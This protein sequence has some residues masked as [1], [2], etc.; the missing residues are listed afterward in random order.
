[1]ILIP[2]AIRDQLLEN[3]RAMA[4]LACTPDEPDFQPL[5][6]LF[7]PDAGCTWLLTEL[8]PEDPDIAV[9]LCDLG[10]GCPEL[11]SVRVSELE[12]LRGKLGMPV[13]RDLHFVARQTISQYAAEAS[14]QGYIRA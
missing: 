8:D 1:M 13:E 11:G 5:I 14:R 10:L 3:G 12:A 4:R 6:K 7:T 2:D 9:G